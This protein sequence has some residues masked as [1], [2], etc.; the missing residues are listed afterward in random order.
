M[1][2]AVDRNL[3]REQIWFSIEKM[4]S[5]IPSHSRIVKE[6]VLIE[7]PDIPFTFTDKGTLKQQEIVRNYA[8]LIDQAYASAS[9]GWARDVALPSKMDKEA[10][11][12]SL[13]SATASLLNGRKLDSDDDLFEHGVPYVLY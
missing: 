2:P 7:T 3:F 10:I 8:G 11:F 13:A 4:N 9:S 6:L 5:I 12:E 1:D